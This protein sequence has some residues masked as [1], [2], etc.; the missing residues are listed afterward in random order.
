M[1]NEKKG[2][3][4]LH[5]HGVVA[6]R[7]CT[8][9]WFHFRDK[10][11]HFWEQ[12]SM[13]TCIPRA[14][15]G[16]KLLL[17]TAVLGWWVLVGGGCGHL[18]ISCQQAT[19]RLT[20]V[21]ASCLIKESSILLNLHLGFYEALDSGLPHKQTRVLTSQVGTQGHQN[22]MSPASYLCPGP[23]HISFSVRQEMATLAGFLTFLMLWS[24]AI[25]PHIVVHPHTKNYFCCYFITNFYVVINHAESISVFRWP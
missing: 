20:I 12:W 5:L 6:C 19:P 3:S 25:V 23:F 4:S 15:V 10:C 21:K 17:R 2:P 24:F 11:I 14:T 13:V 1:Q 18:W 22:P 8:S 16:L 7:F 9:L